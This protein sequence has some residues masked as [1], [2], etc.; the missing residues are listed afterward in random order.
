[1]FE[2]SCIK[3]EVFANLGYPTDDIF[4]EITNYY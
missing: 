4:S 1:M 2:F 3:A